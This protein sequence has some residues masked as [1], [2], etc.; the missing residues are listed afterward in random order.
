MLFAGNENV[1]SQWRQKQKKMDPVATISICG[2]S[3]KVNRKEKY[4]IPQILKTIKTFRNTQLFYQSDII[5]YIYFLHSG[6][7]SMFLM[8]I[9]PELC[10]GFQ[11]LHLVKMKECKG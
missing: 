5:K 8:K 10:R 4:K 6:L 1:A 9:F 11:D 2:K 7:L 3:R